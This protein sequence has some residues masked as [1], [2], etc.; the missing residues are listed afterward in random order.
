[1]LGGLVLL[2]LDPRYLSL[3]GAAL[4]AIALAFAEAAHRRIEPRPA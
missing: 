1:V 3:V 4:I 2:F